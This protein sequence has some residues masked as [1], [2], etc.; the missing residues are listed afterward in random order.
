LLTSINGRDGVID[1]IDNGNGFDP[2]VLDRVFE[3]YQRGDR[4]GEAGIGLAIVKGIVT[5]H[6][7]SVSAANRPDGGAV[8]RLG[9][10]L[11]RS[12]HN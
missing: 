3:R 12:A 11:N 6:G 1:V 5:A 8:V 7:G 9:I 10:P 2:A 4:R